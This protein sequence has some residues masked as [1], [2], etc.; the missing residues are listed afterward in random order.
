MWGLSS[1]SV[2]DKQLHNIG[3]LLWG[4][5]QHA[6]VRCIKYAKVQHKGDRQTKSQS[7]QTNPRMPVAVV[8]DAITRCTLMGNAT[9]AAMNTSD[10]RPSAPMNI[11]TPLVLTF[12]ATGICFKSSVSDGV[13][14]NAPSALSV[15]SWD[16]LVI[17]QPICIR[18]TD[19]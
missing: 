14:T 4:H 18:T 15:R 12:R 5:V 13:I 11:T 6:V 7:H 19:G 8:P 3:L 9:P 10:S 1:N 17:L 2:A 16:R